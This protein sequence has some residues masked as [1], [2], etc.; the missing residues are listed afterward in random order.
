[1]HDSE[2]R[3]L[4]RT[5]FL[6]FV[7]SAVR[8]MWPVGD[9]SPDVASVANSLLAASQER[10]ADAEHRSRPL[11]PGERIDPNSASAQELDRLPGVGAVAA[12]AIVAERE[13][14]GPFR[15][16]G[17]LARVRGIGPATV[18]KLAPHIAVS[19]PRALPSGRTRRSGASTEAAVDINRATVAEL[20]ALPGI[21]PALAAR[22]VEARQERVFQ[23]VEDLVN[24]RGIG[25]VTLE[26]LL[27]LVTA[28]GGRR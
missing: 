2:T 27:P 21:G 23:R 11:E 28:G 14:G 13:L 16:V 9:V 26:R 6:L 4:R 12:Q 20:V 5:A 22:I 19:E 15:D 1:M 25:L 3:A 17:D 18:A 8:L 10:L 24:V 7:V